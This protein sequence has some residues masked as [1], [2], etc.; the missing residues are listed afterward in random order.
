MPPSR[1]L[2]VKIAEQF[3]AI[4]NPENPLNFEYDEPETKKSEK[5]GHITATTTTTLASITVSE[6]Q[7][8]ISNKKDQHLTP[9]S[10]VEQ[11][12]NPTPSQTA[13]ARGNVRKLVIPS[14]SSS[15]SE[16]DP[17]KP[18]FSGKGRNRSDSY[19]DGESES[20][21]SSDSLESLN[22]EDDTSDLKK[23]K[24][25]VYIRECLLGLRSEE[26]EEILATLNVVT[27]LI[28]KEPGEYSSPFFD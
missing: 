3:S 4:L 11:H 21:S 9:Q 24:I 5:T 13:A 23:I 15:S 8:Q 19:S 6:R 2:L 27:G 18:F 26:P 10:L 25:P 1:Y 28:K 22:L 12:Y 16:C 17:D 7:G 14:S 20:E